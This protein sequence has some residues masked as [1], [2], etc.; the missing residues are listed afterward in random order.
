VA[1]LVLFGI[2]AARGGGRSGRDRQSRWSEQSGSIPT[3]F[4]PAPRHLAD[5]RPGVDKV[6]YI[7]FG[8]EVVVRLPPPRDIYEVVTIVNSALKAQ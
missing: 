4:G 8:G 3:V 1:G 6:R 2:G 7:F 5:L